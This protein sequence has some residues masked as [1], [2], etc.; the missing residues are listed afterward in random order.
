MKVNRRE[1]ISATVIGAGWTAGRSAHLFAQASPV[2]GTPT[3]EGVAPRNPYQYLENFP[4]FT[5]T[6][7]DVTEGEE[8]GARFRGEQAVSPQLAWTGQPEG[9][10]SYIVSCYDADAPTPSGFW[11]WG[12]FNVP[13]ETSELVQGAGAADSMDLPEGSVSIAN[14][15]GSFQYIGPAPNP[16][17]PHR[18]FFAVLALDVPTLDLTKDV[19]PAVMYFTAL[20]HLLGYGLLVPIATP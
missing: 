6:S 1:M 9:T 7:T 8:I 20:G 14:D 19:S 18:Y 4:T 12:V 17:P 13:G 15:V 11:H 10:Q 16:G 3:V 2:A 5:V